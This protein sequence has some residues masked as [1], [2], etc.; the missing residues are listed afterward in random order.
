MIDEN[1]KAWIDN[2]SYIELLRRWRFAPAG[3]DS[4]FQGE[5]GR[6][7]EEVMMRRR[8]EVGPGAAVAASKAVGWDGP[9]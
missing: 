4:Y 6:Y 9:N 3:T 1:I 8:N 5:T 7:Y 2:A